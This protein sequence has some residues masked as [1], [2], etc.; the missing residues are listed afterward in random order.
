M[1]LGRSEH[2]QRSV[3]GSIP[4]G[5]GIKLLAKPA[6]VFGLVVD[7]REHPAKEK[8]VAGFYRLNVGSKW[9][10]GSRELN[11]KLQQPA[12]GTTCTVHVQHLPLPGTDSCNG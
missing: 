5:L 6:E 11:A 4:A 1:L 3:L 12:I 7:D 8:Q 10:W 9:R 2:V